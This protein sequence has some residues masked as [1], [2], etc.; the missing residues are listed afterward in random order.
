MEKEGV[1]EEAKII[2]DMVEEFLTGENSVSRIY[3]VLVKC[4]RSPPPF[5]FLKKLVIEH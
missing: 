5:K 1:D 2:L 4:C 3:S